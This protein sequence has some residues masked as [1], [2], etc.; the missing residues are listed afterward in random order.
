[1]CWPWSTSSPA[2]LDVLAL[3]NELTG[4]ALDVLVMVDELTGFHKSGPMPSMRPISWGSARNRRDRTG[5]EAVKMAGV[6]LGYRASWHDRG[7]CER[8]D[9]GGRSRGRGPPRPLSGLDRFGR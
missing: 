4:A 9:S 1:M 2:A 8:H 5:R 3:V 6:V 7:P